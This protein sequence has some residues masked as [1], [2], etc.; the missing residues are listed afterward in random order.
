M[1][2]AVGEACLLDLD[3]NK[4]QIYLGGV[5]IVRDGG[6]AADYTEDQGQ[7]VMKNEE[8]EVRIELNRGAVSETV[9]TCDFSYDYVKINA[10]YRS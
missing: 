6:R 2:A 5:C 10:E 8:I 4:L 7:K 3:V 9:W 1:L